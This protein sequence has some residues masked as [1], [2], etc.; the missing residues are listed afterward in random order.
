M[1]YSLPCDGDS[2][3]LLRLHRDDGDVCPVGLVEV[4]PVFAPSD[5]RFTLSATMPPLPDLEPAVT[6]PWQDVLRG[7]VE[8]FCGA[9]GE[10]SG[11]ELARRSARSVAC[12]PLPVSQST[13]AWWET[14]S[15][16]GWSLQR[17]S[18]ISNGR[19]E[20]RITQQLLAADSAT[21]LT[22]LALHNSY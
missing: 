2:A 21:A 3:E 11:S 10:S 13:L 6:L 1:Q 20:H 16:A 5:N 8:L 9:D 17:I 19:T 15:L 14:G 4:F 22:C 18:V 12:A 7:D